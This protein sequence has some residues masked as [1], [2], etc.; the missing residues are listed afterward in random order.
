[1]IDNLICRGKRKCDNEWIEGDLTQEKY[2][3]GKVE[4]YII[5]NWEYTDGIFMEVLA[6]EVIPETVGQFTGYHECNNDLGKKIFQGDLLQSIHDC[7]EQYEV[8]W[9]LGGWMIKDSITIQYLDELVEELEIIGNV[10]DDEESE[11]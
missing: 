11:L 3:G 7:E 5:E 2:L 6:R 1:M 8:V 4:S 9:E 10:Y